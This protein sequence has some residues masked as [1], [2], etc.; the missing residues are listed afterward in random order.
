M[1]F[2]S[3]L[4]KIIPVVVVGLLLMAGCGDDKGTN[5]QEHLIGTWKLV[6]LKIDFAGIPANV[7]EMLGLD[8]TLE[9]RDDGTYTLT[10]VQTS[11]G[12][13]DVENGTWTAGDKTITINPDDDDPK[14]MNYTIDGNTATLKTTLPNVV[15]QEDEDLMSNI[16]RDMFN[17]DGTLM[18]TP[19]T[20][21][22]NKIG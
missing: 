19:V 10:T 15:D 3:S 16:P 22:Y 14:T 6:E 13:T 21:V 8:L 20:L 12:T 4:S 11:E 18:D 1:Y 2:H 17:E 9:V 5:S 7:L